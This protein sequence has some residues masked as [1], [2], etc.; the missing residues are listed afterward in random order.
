MSNHYNDAVTGLVG[1]Q[2]LYGK[3]D[4][5]QQLSARASKTLPDLEPQHPQLDDDRLGIALGTDKP[6]KLG[7]KPGE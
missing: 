5:F 6:G 1:K 7:H 4:R 2:G 3:V